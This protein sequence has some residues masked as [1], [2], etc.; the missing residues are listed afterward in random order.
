MSTPRQSKIMNRVAKEVLKPIGVS[1]KGQSK[2]WYD[3]NGWWITVV[4]FQPSGWSKSTY[5]NIG[6]NWQWYPEKQISLDFGYREAGYIHYES[7]EQFEPQARMFAETAKSKIL[8]IR[9]LLST[10]HATKQYIEYTQRQKKSVLWGEFHQGMA[11]AIAGDTDEAITLFHQVINDP[12]DT[13]WARKLKGFTRNIVSRISA[14][15]DFY[16]YV[17]SI[18]NQSR[19]LKNLKGTSRRFAPA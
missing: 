9:E 4:E 11:C 6:V 16:G 19:R 12:Y 2:T 8:E 5:L 14:N 10:P 3:D 15:D 18:V 1:Q 13:A 17:N 7:D